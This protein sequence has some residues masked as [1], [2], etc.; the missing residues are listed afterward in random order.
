MQ[1]AKIVK[2]IIAESFE[3]PIEKITNDS[4]ILDISP[5][6]NYFNFLLSTIEARLGIDICTA[7]DRYIKTVADLINAVKRPGP[8]LPSD[9]FY[10]ERMDRLE[11]AGLA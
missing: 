8:P 1:T 4:I 10:H 2:E 9:R 11:K 7:R 6:Q 3:I 5:D